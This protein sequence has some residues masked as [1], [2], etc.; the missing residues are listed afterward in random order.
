[1]DTFQKLVAI[2]KNKEMLMLPFQERQYTTILRWISKCK[3]QK[4]NPR[5]QNFAKMS[6]EAIEIKGQT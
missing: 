3:Y 6:F 1:M 5:I 4:K 2:P